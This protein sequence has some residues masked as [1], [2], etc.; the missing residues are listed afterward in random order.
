MR[1]DLQAI[2]ELEPNLM[3][4]TFEILELVNAIAK[5]VADEPFIIKMFIT[6]QT[7]SGDTSELVCLPFQILVFYFKYQQQEG[8]LSTQD[9][10]T[11]RSVI[12]KSLQ[13]QCKE[14]AFTDYLAHESDFVDIFT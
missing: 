9:R 10:V 8:V 1:P 3:D 14:A 5:R 2:G 13:A 4:S 12:L 6:R 11:L 7:D